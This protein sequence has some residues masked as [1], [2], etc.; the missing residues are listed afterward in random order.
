MEIGRIKI[1]GEDHLTIKVDKKGGTLKHVWP[2]GDVNEI[3]F[4]RKDD[5]RE[6]DG[7]DPEKCVNLVG[8]TNTILLVGRYDPISLEVPMVFSKD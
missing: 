7:R 5:G 6:Y 4:G 3:E 1:N 8:R 2:D